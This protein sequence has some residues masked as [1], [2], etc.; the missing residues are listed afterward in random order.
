MTHNWVRITAQ[1]AFQ[2]RPND[3]LKEISSYGPTKFSVVAAVAT[4]KVDSLDTE[5]WTW[6]AIDETGTTVSYTLTKRFEHYGPEVYVRRDEV[7]Q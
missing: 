1:N 6:E 5:Q 3:K 4:R 7:S 2:L